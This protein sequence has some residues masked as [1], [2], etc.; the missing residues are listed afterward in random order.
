MS[1]KLLLSGSDMDLTNQEADRL[2]AEPFNNILA[3]TV[4]NFNQGRPVAV[5]NTAER[6]LIITAD[7]FESTLADLVTLKQSQ[8]FD[9][10]VVNLTT[11]GGNTTTAIKTI[12]KPNIKVLIHLFMFI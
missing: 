3:P 11:V 7:A 8:G 4:L 6:I 5:P 9:V 2:N 10:S 1:F 12:L